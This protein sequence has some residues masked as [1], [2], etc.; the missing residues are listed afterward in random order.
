MEKKTRKVIIIYTIV[1]M[2]FG[3]MFPM[4]AFIFEHITNQFPL[5]IEGIKSA[6]MQINLMYM[7]DTAPL[8]LGLF[9]FIAGLN[10]AKS[11]E[12]NFNLIHLTGDL[13]RAKEELEEK[14]KIL[15]RDALYD[16]ITGLKNEKAM[17]DEEKKNEKVVIY[18]LNISCLSEINS[19]FGYDIGD[20]IMKVLAERLEDNNFTGYKLNGDRFAIVDYVDIN[21]E[22]ID[23][24]ANYIFEIISSEPFDIEEN[25]IFMTVRIGAAFY[26]GKTDGLE[27]RSVLKEL[28]YNANYALKYAKDKTMPYAI[29]DDEMGKKRK[30]QDNHEWKSK[31]I[32]AIKSGNIAAYY[33]PIIN[34][35]TGE[36]EKYEALIRLIDKESLVISPIHFLPPSKKYG[37]Y[38]YLTR[39]IF[40]EA[41]AAIME[42]GHEI[43]V[44]ISIEDIRNMSTHRLIMK[45]IE[46]FPKANLIVF[47]LLESEGI[48]NYDEVRKFINSVKKYGCKIAIDDFGSGYSNFGHVLNLNVDYIKIDASLIKNI[49]KDINSEYITKTIVKFAKSIGAKT[50]AEFVHSKEVYEKVKEA[51]VDYSQGFYLGEP[52]KHF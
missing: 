33:Q 25:E 40:L 22:E 44:N 4:G 32:K 23:T 27:N 9:A 13:K 30:E 36:I 5:T 47:E 38:D 16:R 1:G 12:K 41:C 20:R 18:I 45:K 31:I 29:Y 28:L 39:I 35:K 42:N 50:I 52:K 7:I 46:E 19:L 49:D 10:H 8:F 34:N 21:I 3:A 43:S 15:Y 2:L 37:L 24:V 6:H 26:N 51:E 11:L 48:E 14:N 17:F